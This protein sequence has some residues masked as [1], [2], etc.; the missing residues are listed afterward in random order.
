MNNHYVTPLVE[1][2]NEGDFVFVFDPELLMAPNLIGSRARTAN[3]GF[4]FNVP[5]PSS[6]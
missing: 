3:V 5:F 4:F 6:G 1:D 2:C